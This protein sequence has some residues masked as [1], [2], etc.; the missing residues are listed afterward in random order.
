MPKPSK[1]NANL[2]AAL[3]ASGALAGGVAGVAGAEANGGAV[4]PTSAVSAG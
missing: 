2:I 4:G 3:L 1:R